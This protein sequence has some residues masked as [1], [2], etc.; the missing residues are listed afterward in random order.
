MYM[1]IYTHTKGKASSVHYT[2][3]I[4]H[5]NLLVMYTHTSERV[6]VSVRTRCPW[7]ISSYRRLAYRLLS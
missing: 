4:V 3:Y 1:C 5:A 2:L 6:T 7:F